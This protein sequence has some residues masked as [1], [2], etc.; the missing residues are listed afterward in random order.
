MPSEQLPHLETFTEAAERASFTAA[1]NVLGIS[2]AAVSQRIQQ[3]EGILK[4]SL[5]HRK[6]GRIS[7]TE[8]G[9]VL[10]QY[11]RK[12]LALHDEAKAK[13][14]GTFAGDSA[15]LL[16]AASSVP[17]EQMLPSIL[18][19]FRQ[20]YPNIHVC[21]T[22]TDTA[23]VLRDIRRGQVHLG[24]V[25]GKDEKA[26]LAYRLF[27]KEKMVL[28]VPKNH[29]LSRRRSVSIE[30]LLSQPIIQREPGSASRQNFEDDLRAAGH[31]PRD[32]RI[33][34]ELGSNESI[35]EAI[36]QG[37]GAAVLSVSAVQKEADEGKFHLLSVKGLQLTREFYIVHD[38]KR[39][40]PCCANM[41]LA[42]FPNV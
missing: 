41:L 4:V 12:I 16:L 36:L 30:T 13:L 23:A 37:V 3:I 18:A 1:A 11:A 32:I 38:A 39:A 42:F 20:S 10:H 26:N 21:L 35:K 28:V 7:L 33:V 2:Q 5:F 27:G 22:V 29:P 9:R 25:G 6:N 31:S 14:R 17:G 24:I 15:E 8:Q 19:S 34:M 40:L